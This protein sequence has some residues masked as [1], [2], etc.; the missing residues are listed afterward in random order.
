LKFK[1]DKLEHLHKFQLFNKIEKLKLAT[2]ENKTVSSESLIFHTIDNKLYIYISN[3]I[4]SAYSYICEVED[5]FRSFAVD[6]SSFTNA[7]SNFPSNEIQFSILFDENQLVFGNKKT[8]VSLKTSNVESENI[9]FHDL[10]LLENN[11]FL[12]LDVNNL[13][14][15]IK[16]SSFSCAPDYDEYP[17]TS[18]MFFIKDNIFNTQSSDKH[19]ISMFGQKY[20]GDSSFLISKAQAELMKEFI[21][22]TSSKYTVHKG[23]FYILWENGGFSCAIENNTHQSV[24]NTFNQFFDNSELITSFEI[25]KND[26]LKS[27]RFISSISSNH[28]FFM[29]SSGSQLIFS[30]SNNEKGAVID[31]IQ[32]SEE[33]V[34]FEASYLVNHFIKVL[35]IINKEDTTLSFY[36]YNGYTI[37]IVEDLDFKHL[38]FPM[39]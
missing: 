8:R 5:D 1:L 17:Y 11:T 14:N 28:N 19:R 4:S 25:N 21:S 31:K 6:A 23:K 29:K 18:I 22:K 12:D 35:D 39:E 2:R 27:L 15:A 33:I 3:G 9:N 26:I 24:Y 16:Y 34:E 36:D 37:C 20:D 30:S 10:F 32:L 13:L 7:L 38:M